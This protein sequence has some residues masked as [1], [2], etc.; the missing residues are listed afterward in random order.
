VQ[1]GP[2]S[3][4][5]STFGLQDICYGPEPVVTRVFFTVRDLSWHSPA[6]DTA[7]AAPHVADGGAYEVDFS[8][9][10]D[11]LPL[12]LAGRLTLGTDALRADF[13]LSVHGPVGL[14]R[15]GPAVLYPPDII[16]HEMVAHSEG[17][18]HRFVL[19]AD[20]EPWPLASGYRALTFSAGGPAL[21]AEFEGDLFELEDQR[22]WAD[23]TFKSYCPPLA[24]DRP[25][26]LGPGSQRSYSVT[27]RPAGRTGGPRRA[28]QHAPYLGLEPC[29]SPTG[30][31]LP[32]LGLTHPG[33]PLGP[34]AA[35]LLAGA[36]LGFVH[37]LVDLGEGD[38][39]KTLAAD[40]A[41]LPGLPGTA[42]LTVECPEG[43]WGRLAR[44]AEV[45]G[46]AVGTAFLFEAGRSSTSAALAEAARSA[47]A[48]TGLRVGGGSRGHFAELNRDWPL[49]EAAEVVGVALSSAAHDDD[50]QALVSSLGT[51]GPIL[52]HVGRAAGGR[53]VYA[54]PVGFAPTYDPW[55]APEDR[56]PA[57]YMWDRG[58]P[59]QRSVFAAAWT[60]AAVAALAGAGAGEAC[61]FGT[62]GGRG[63]LGADGL[64]VNTTPV[65]SALAALAPLG[66]GPVRAANAGRRVVSLSGDRLSV[67][68]VMSPAPLALVADGPV[69]VLSAGP[70]G[71]LVRGE[72]RPGGLVPSPSIVL[73]DEPVRLHG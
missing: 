50:T 24:N 42:K 10:I 37:L 40:L 43:S 72:V 39:E 17:G 14:A 35:G 19:G 15:A 49:P 55:P 46:G 45:A 73:V 27:L 52:S 70:D 69:A 32:V 16:G 66:H 5:L 54:G 28:G 64:R 44:L 4:S 59:R 68:S 20:I 26:D 23:A 25:L 53:Q 58:H 51:F 34:E 9:R 31:C 63:V 13:H 71:T 62:T 18:G 6:V 12:G 29:P 47:W 38:W 22:N 61:L 65:F 8:A 36:G 33:G 3:V 60:V 1:V 48:G 2:W 30:G 57:R 21:T 67:V 7:W 41:G 11:G 56:A